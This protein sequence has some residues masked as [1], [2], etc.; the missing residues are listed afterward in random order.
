MS[1]YWFWVKLAIRFWQVSNCISVCEAVPD[2]AMPVCRSKAEHRE[3]NTHPL[4]NVAASPSLL[5]MRAG[6]GTR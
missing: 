5:S 1:G 2:A 6:S 4:T 3:V